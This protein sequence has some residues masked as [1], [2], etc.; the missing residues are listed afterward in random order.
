MSNSHKSR[1][2]QKRRASRRLKTSPGRPRSQLASTELAKEARIQ[3][4]RKPI[5]S[6]GTPP[7]RA[8][9]ISA[10]NWQQILR[11][12]LKNVPWKRLFDEFA[13]EAP[14]PIGVN[15]TCKRSIDSS[16]P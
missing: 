3:V 4:T 8:A 11:Q 9:D 16:H 15:K 12:R 14:D 2:T 7:S 6:G 10:L 13:G 1:K 5:G